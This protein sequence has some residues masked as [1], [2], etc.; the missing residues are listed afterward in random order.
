MAEP[1]MYERALG[2]DFEQLPEAVQ[3]FHRL[4]GAWTLTGE[5]ETEAPTTWLARCL[6]WGLGTPRRATR[7]AIRFELLASPTVETW[8]RHF[9]AQSMQSTLRLQGRELQESLGLSRLRFRLAASPQGLEMLLVELHFLGLPCPRWLRPRIV[10]REQ[11]RG[12]RLHFEVS[13]DVPFIGRVAGY[14]GHL[15]L[16]EAP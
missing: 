5:V 13:A 9:P 6:A 16:P 11:G 2:A 10:A 1:S 7:G 15:D 3:R 12:Q 8:R 14:R 4:Q